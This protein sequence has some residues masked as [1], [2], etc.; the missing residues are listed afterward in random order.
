MLVLNNII[1]Y[2]VSLCTRLV[3]VAVGEQMEPI[4]VWMAEL[5]RGSDIQLQIQYFN[6]AFSFCRNKCF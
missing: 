1:N 3:F 6:Q 5:I 2:S 4:S